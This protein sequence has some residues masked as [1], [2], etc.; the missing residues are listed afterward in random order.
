MKSPTVAIEIRWRRIG[1]DANA[2]QVRRYLPGAK[3][4]IR[5]IERADQ[6]EVEACSIGVG[7]L[8]SVWVAVNVTVPNTN[9]TGALALPTNVVGNQASMWDVDTSV[10]Y[11]AVSDAS[12]ES[13]A[14]ISVSAG[15]MVI[16]D[17]SVVYGASSAQITGQAGETVLIY[18]YY[19]DP[20]W[21]GGSRPLGITTNKVQSSNVRGRI[22]ITQLTLK[23][24]PAG[25]SGGGGG[26]IGGG[27]GG[28]GASPPPGEAQQQL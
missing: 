14:T 7:D 5:A 25:E 27:G 22:A 6:Y 8:R 18:L 15:T 9:R 19:D 26:G 12:G 23:F 16:A 21:Q 20:F 10:T 17:K 1:E 4:E 3:A 28:G 2:W 11:A 24:P 13:E